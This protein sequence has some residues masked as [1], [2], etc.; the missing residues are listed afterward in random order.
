MSSRTLAKLVR[1]GPVR[2]HHIEDA[3]PI[4]LG[5]VGG[6]EV[7][8]PL[9]SRE[10]DMGV[11]FEIDSI[12]PPSAPWTEALETRHIRTVK[13][14]DV[15][16][17]GLF[18]HLR[19]VPPLL[20]IEFMEGEDVTGLLGVTKRL[21]PQ[22]DLVQPVAE[23]ALHSGVAAG[24]HRRSA[25][26]ESALPG[27]PP[28]TGEPRVQSNMEL[29]ESLQGRPYYITLKYDGTSATYGYVGDEFKAL[30]RNFVAS[31]PSSE[32]WRVAEIY[33]LQGKMVKYQHW[34]VQGEI[35]GPG[36]LKNLLNLKRLE[37]RVFNVWDKN[38][39]RFLQFEGL[40]AAIKN[41][42]KEQKKGES[43]KMVDVVETGDNFQYDL[44]ELLRKAAEKNYPGTE[45]PQE[46]IVVRSQT[47][48]RVS[49][50]TISSAYLIKYRQ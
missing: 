5:Q 44:D 33:D 7:I 39:Q 4:Y 25:R 16:T 47:E 45:N 23:I 42:N 10:G 1:L 46:G 48:P 50:K 28:K 30:S 6:W 31:K 36:L 26:A 2:K 40:Q 20:D 38:L 22:E 21:D 13:I 19:D 11:Y 8:V 3:P 15:V 9:K 24:P 14:G 37:F 41:L 35:V 17:Q 34:V 32:Y 18:R 29:L 12:L 27:G 43:L 49:F